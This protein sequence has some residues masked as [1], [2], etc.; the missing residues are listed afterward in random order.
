MFRLKPNPQLLIGIVKLEL[1][2][3][4]KKMLLRVKSVKSI[5][6]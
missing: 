5:G 2:A 1:R 3:A 4:A 6:K